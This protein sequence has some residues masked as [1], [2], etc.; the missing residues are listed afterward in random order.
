VSDAKVRFETLDF[1]AAT[2][3]KEQRFEFNCP[4]HDRRCGAL[5]IAGRTALPRDG[6]NR[7]GGIAQ[8]D[9]NGD[10][11]RPTF[12]PS[13]NCQGCW[14]GYIRNGRAVDCAGNDEPEILRSK[15]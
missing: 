4:R 14:H 5:V 3:G 13:V 12:T 10:R 1:E 9:W 6:Q 7:N 2:P 15:T 11:E 8:W